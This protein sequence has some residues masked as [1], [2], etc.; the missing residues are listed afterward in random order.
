MWEFFDILIREGQQIVE[1]GEVYVL[2][3]YEAMFESGIFIDKYEETSCSRNEYGNY[4]FF[5]FFNITEKTITCLNFQGS[6]S[7]LINVLE[8]YKH[9]HHKAAGTRIVLFAVSRR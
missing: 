6:A 7:L 8:E 1:L 5:E 2:Q 9:K 4:H 3:Q